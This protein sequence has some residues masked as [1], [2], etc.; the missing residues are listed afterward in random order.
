VSAGPEAEAQGRGTQVPFGGTAENPRRKNTH[1]TL[2]ARET[3]WAAKPLYIFNS[4]CLYKTFYK[5]VPYFRK[6][7]IP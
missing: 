3:A 4:V 1:E 5:P 6:G 7:R 2:A